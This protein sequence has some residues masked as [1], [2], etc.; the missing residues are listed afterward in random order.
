MENGGRVGLIGFGWACVRGGQIEERLLGSL[1]GL[2]PGL[3]K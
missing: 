3:Y 2:K 1:A